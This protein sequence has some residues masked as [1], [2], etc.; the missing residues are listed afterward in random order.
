MCAVKRRARRKP[1]ARRHLLFIRL[2]R[3]PAG[4]TLAK[5]PVLPQLRRRRNP[6]Q[7]NKPQRPNQN[8]KLFEK[9]PHQKDCLP[10]VGAWMH[11]V[12]RISSR[13][14]NFFDAQTCRAKAI[15]V[16]S[17]KQREE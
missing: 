11:P 16:G 17:T 1:F 13:D 6:S 15:V 12:A 5:N 9:L 10:L 2:R 3:I 7:R 14:T 8:E 4:L